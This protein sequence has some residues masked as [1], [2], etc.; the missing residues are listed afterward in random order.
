M[1][2]IT[3]MQAE[4]KTICE[5]CGKEKEGIGFFI[6]ATNIPDWCMIAGSGKI[7]CPECYKKGVRKN[8]SR[9]F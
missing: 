4:N 8:G 1:S 9:R 2:L 6:G 3:K 5:F 7:A